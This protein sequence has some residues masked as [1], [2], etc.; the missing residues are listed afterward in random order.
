MAFVFQNLFPKSFVINRLQKYLKQDVFFSDY[1][2]LEQFLQ[3]I[4]VI[5]G[6]EFVHVLL[7]LYNFTEVEMNNKHLPYG[8]PFQNSILLYLL[9]L[10]E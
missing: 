5:S 7:V 4:A 8:F 1:V 10:A 9:K 6:I 3:P 2:Q